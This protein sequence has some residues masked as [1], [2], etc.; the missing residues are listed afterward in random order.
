LLARVL[1]GVVVWGFGRLAVLFGVAA[2]VDAV[3]FGVAVLVD[4]VDNM[5]AKA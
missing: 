1:A 5:T 2:L 3:L 4:G